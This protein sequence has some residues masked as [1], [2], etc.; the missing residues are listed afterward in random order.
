MVTGTSTQAS[1]NYADDNDEK[2]L[3]EM[4][5]VWQPTGSQS[6]GPDPRL[7]PTVA[8]LVRAVVL[9]DKTSSR[10][11]KIGFGLTVAGLALTGVSLAPILPK[12]GP[13]I[14]KFF[15]PRSA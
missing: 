4:H 9:L 7:A 11:T 3:A 1:E 10:L 14:R 5:Q 6:N 2:L 15:K 13:K 12:T 8:I